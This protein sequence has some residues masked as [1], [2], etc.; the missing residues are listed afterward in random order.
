[1]IYKVKFSN[2]MMKN[3]NLNK[4]E[5]KKKKEKDVQKYKIFQMHKLMKNIIEKLMKLN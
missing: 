1:M 3:I 2:M 5:L 4:K